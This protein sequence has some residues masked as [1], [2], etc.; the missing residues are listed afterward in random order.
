MGTNK[1]AIWIVDDEQGICASLMFALKRHYVTKSFPDSQRMFDCMRKESCDLVLLDLKLGSED[2]LDVLRRIKAL[3]AS[4]VVV[5]MTAHATIETTV[6]A[7]RSG[8]YTYLTKPLDLDELKIVVSQAL[9]F[10]SLSKQVQSLNDELES[11]RHY[12]RIIGESPCMKAVYELIDALKD[13]DSSVL[14]TGESGTGKEL[15][16]KAI[17]SEGKRGKERFVVVNCAAIPENLLESEFFGYRK[18][19]FTGA[20]EDRKGKLELANH[21]TL[22]LDEIGDMPLSLQVKILRVLQD[23]E[24]TPV[25]AAEPRRVDVRV[26]AATNRDLNA[27]IRDKKFREDLYYRLNVMSIEI[28]PLRERKEDILLLCDNFLQKNAV[29]MKKNIAGLSEEVKETLLRYPYPG[30][31]R[32]LANILEYACIVCKGSRIELSDLPRDIRELHSSRAQSEDETESEFL[33]THTLEEIERKAILQTLEKN[34]G[35]RGKTAEDLGI[36][37]RCLFNKIREYGL[38]E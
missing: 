27:L 11:S 35:H 13:I 10:R 32:Q 2:G 14:I 36:S 24:F 15:V 23:K 28:P 33:S 5:I 12:S 18:G 21:G 6:E 8:A 9:E 4:I 25:G 1:P 19:A 30:N 22:F 29:E 17:H 34:K 3:D 16:A 26:I 37:R 31:V 20:D 7:M 38:E